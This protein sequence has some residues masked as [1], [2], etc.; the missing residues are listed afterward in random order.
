MG[1]PNRPNRPL[2]VLMLRVV[3]ADPEPGVSDVLVNVHEDADGKLE[4]ASL[5]AEV[6]LPPSALTV[7]V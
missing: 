6:K 2:E 4:H 3:L 7:I 5:I 1:V